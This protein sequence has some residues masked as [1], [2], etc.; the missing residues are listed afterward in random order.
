MTISN[1]ITLVRVSTTLTLL[2][3]IFYNAHWSVGVMGANLWIF[4]ELTA[5][6]FRKQNHRNELVLESIT[7]MSNRLN[8]AKL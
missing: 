8:R 4:A 2:G 7:L 6:N 1:L 3:F 5:S